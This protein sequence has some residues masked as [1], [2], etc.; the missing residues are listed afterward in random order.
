MRHLQIALSLKLRRTGRL[1]SLI[2]KS[3]IH[4]FFLVVNCHNIFL[5]LDPHYKPIF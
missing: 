1:A 4:G 2:K 5:K 3:L